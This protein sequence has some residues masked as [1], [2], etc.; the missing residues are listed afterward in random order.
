MNTSLECMPC[1][2]KMA[3]RE[4]RL[5]CPDD[6]A[7]HYEILV[8][9]GRML[10]E[11]DLSSPP[12][13]IARHLTEMIREQTECG[14]LYYDDKQAANVRVME[15]LPSLKQL[16]EAERA[17]PKGDPIAL[18]LELAIIGNYI[19][20]GIDL[21]VDWEAELANVSESLPDDVLSEFKAK[22]LPGAN[23]LIL[24]DNTGEIVLDMLLVEELQKKKCDVTYAVRS[25]PV[26]N[27][28]TYTDA[29]MVGM[30]KLCRVV[31]SGVDTPGTVLNRCL[32]EF[33]DRMKDADLII[34][35]GQGNFEA[36]EGNWPEIFCAF[37]VKCRR[38]AKDS[39]LD[40][41]SSAFYI[42]QKDGESCR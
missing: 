13:A 23:I 5:A 18:S 15:L 36:L 11:L 4:A 30:T 21:D 9:W 26:I 20:R 14:D 7:K 35:K 1:F 32:P 8:T 12:P 22:L 19:D 27:D 38:V 41:N 28:C 39:G 40:L 17:K 34:S 24:G 29:E 33:I 2:M 10:G 37:K 42:T 31:E 16:V 3:L 25:K 6:E